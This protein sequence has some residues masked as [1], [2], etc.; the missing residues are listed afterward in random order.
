MDVGLIPKADNKEVVL[1]KN[2]STD[3]I[4][5]VVIEA[6]KHKP[7]KGFCQFAKQFDRSYEGLRDLWSFVKYKILYILSSFLP[8]M[9]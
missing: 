7:K 9:L 1:H 8:R 2:G 4:M 3:D 6:T 5:E